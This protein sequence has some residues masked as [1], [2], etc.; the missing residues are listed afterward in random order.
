M[1]LIFLAMLCV[2]CFD[3]SDSLDASQKL[4][5]ATG[6]LD[7]SGTTGC[8][9]EC[10]KYS[11]E[12]MKA[13]EAGQLSRSTE[14]SQKSM[15][16]TSRCEQ[17]GGRAA[18]KATGVGNNTTGCLARCM[19]YSTKAMKLAEAGDLSGSAAMS[20]KSMECTSRCE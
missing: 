15:A 17:G 10:M 16:C 18:A 3:A 6:A 13:A 1:K 19:E 14:L 9:A 8:L 7:A 5:S 20:Q 4:M 2:G 11:T 12:A